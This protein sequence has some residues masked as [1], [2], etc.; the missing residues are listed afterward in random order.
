MSRETLLAK[1]AT[2]LPVDLTLDDHL[3]TIF[4]LK[5]DLNT[6]FSDRQRTLMEDWFLVLPQEKS[7]ELNILNKDNVNRAEFITLT[8]GL[9][10]LPVSLLTDC[11]NKETFRHLKEFLSSLKHVKVEKDQ[12]LSVPL[13]FIPKTTPTPVIISIEVVGTDVITVEVFAYPLPPINVSIISPK[14]ILGKI[15]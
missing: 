4:L 11:D 12:F 6:S 15:R 3:V 7:S 5:P 9:Q 1:L 13:L 14:T 8:N 10:V 2:R